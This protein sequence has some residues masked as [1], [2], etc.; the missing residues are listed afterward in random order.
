MWPYIWAGIGFEV[1][2]HGLVV[3]SVDL[4]VLYHGSMDMDPRSPNPYS[5]DITENQHR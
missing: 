5:E 1:I 3:S 4:H 2:V